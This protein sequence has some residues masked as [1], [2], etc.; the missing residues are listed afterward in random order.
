MSIADPHPAADFDLWAD[1]YDHEVTSEGSF[2]FEGYS[3][4]LD[5][6]VSLAE[7]KPGMQVI[8]LGVGT[9][10]LAARFHKAGCRLWCTDFSAL[11]LEK[12]RRRLP[13]AEFILHDLRTSFPA[14]LPRPFDLVVSTYVFHHFPQKEKMTLCSHLVQEMLKPGG[15]LVIGDIVFRSEAEREGTRLSLGE[16]WEEE[17]YWITSLDLPALHDQGLHAVAVQVT[18]YSGV[19]VINNSMDTKMI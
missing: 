11:M 15:R 5:T 16:Q 7:P 17:D 13:H 6:V 4:V 14:N 18:A 2:P 3:R 8:D 19:F 10:N 9:G 12:A 1:T